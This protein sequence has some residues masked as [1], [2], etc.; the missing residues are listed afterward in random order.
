MSRADQNSVLPS[1]LPGSI[2]L[3]SSGE[4]EPIAERSGTEGAS[5]A[6]GGPGK[7]RGAGRRLRIF[8]LLLVVL[9]ALAAAAFL[10]ARHYAGTVMSNNRPKLDGT[11]TVY[12]LAAP[13]EVRRD[14]RGVPHIQA[15]SMNDLIFAQGFV[16]AQDR[17][18]QMDLLRRHASGQLA[19][20][21]ARS[22]IKHDRPQR[23]L[24]FRAAA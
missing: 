10:F 11:L 4:S 2:L 22:V 24:Q 16:T 9:A 14:A 3:R 19:A 20:V 8:G 7:S 15:G 12:G 13:V 18:W 5:T 6:S 17:L 23:T 21:L 1:P